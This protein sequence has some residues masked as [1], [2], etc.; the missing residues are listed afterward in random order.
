MVELAF[1][2]QSLCTE[3]HSM[4]LNVSLVR[5]CFGAIQT[6]RSEFTQRA[7]RQFAL[8]GE[9]F[10]DVARRVDLPRH[11]RTLFNLLKH[12]VEYL[13]EPAHLEDYLVKTGKKYASKG[14]KHEHCDGAVEVVLETF[15]YYFEDQWTEEVQR[16]WLTIL[17]YMADMIREGLDQGGGV[18]ESREPTIDDLARKLARDLFEKALDQEIEDQFFTVA[19]LK[20]KRILKK[21]IE[22]EA[23]TVLEELKTKNRLLR[24]E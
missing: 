14:L 17:E 21:A 10:Q 13:E 1:K 20:A 8:R 3:I 12:V 4:D 5:E 18:P 15:H 16:Q 9:S 6:V 23:K 11:R 2:I 7:I 24:R 19:K 22:S